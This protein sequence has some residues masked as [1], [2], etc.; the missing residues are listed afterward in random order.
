MMVTF[1]INT[2]EHCLE[3]PSGETLL[4][5][6]RRSGYFGV[7]HGCEDGTC[8]AC[9]VLVDGTPV[10]A[11]VTLAAQVAGRHITTIEG[12]GGEQR[13]GWKGSE[14]LHPLQQAFV[15]TG[16]IQCGYCTRGLILA[17]KALLYKSRS[18]SEHEAR[19]QGGDQSRCAKVG[20]GQTG[21]HG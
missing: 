14:P 10:N 4:A 5:L 13:R 9:L 16:A 1:S 6:L 3:S 19:G 21:C 2:L 7:K 18:P 8:G 15:E 11:C 12:I 20:A 17:A